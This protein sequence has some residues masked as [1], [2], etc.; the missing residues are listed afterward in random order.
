MFLYY[1]N[2]NATSDSTLAFLLFKNGGK[3]STL[4]C[5][6]WYYKKYLDKCKK[7]NYDFNWIDPADGNTLLMK[8]CRCP[9]SDD[10][11][12]LVETIQYLITLGAR[13]DIKNK[14]GKTAK[15]IAVNE[16][17]KLFLEEIER[18]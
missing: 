18:K 10:S 16:K 5:D 8:Y 2:D 4:D 1:L 6:I 12:K 13:T 15:E 3:L 7:L 14:M 17:V 9:S 11:D